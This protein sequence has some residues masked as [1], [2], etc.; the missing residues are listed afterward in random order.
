MATPK[1]KGNPPEAFDGK[2]D[3]AETF[4][5]QLENFYYLNEDVYTDESQ[6]VSAALTHFKTGTP[7]GEWAR[8]RTNAALQARP[9]T[10]GTWQDFISAFK[11]HFVPAESALE[12]A[13]Q[14]HNLRQGNRPFNEWYQTWYTHA[15]RAGVDENTKMFAFRRNLNQALHNKI[16]A[17]SP[18]PRTLAALV[19]KARDFDR[20]W[21]LYNS[22]AFTQRPSGMRIRAT[23]Q[24]DPPPATQINALS[25]PN[26]KREKISKEERDRR[27]QNKLCLYC[28]KPNHFAKE[29]RQKKMNAQGRRPGIPPNVRATTSQETTEE[30]PPPEAQLSFLRAATPDT[31]PY[32][33]LRPKSA[34]Q[35]F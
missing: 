11:S 13:A 7:A 25:A 19:E 14:M 27:F 16:I 9:R 1:I 10:F 24:E 15:S 33:I 26:M 18:Q 34:P 28:G 4:L 35:D 30:A 5:S 3:R 23:T 17:L 29:C 8:D 20:V 2:A 31:D 22:P 32:G 6:R 21:H 12:A